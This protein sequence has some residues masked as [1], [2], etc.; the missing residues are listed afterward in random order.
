M[1]MFIRLFISVLFFVSVN[2]NAEELQL[3]NMDK[4]YAMALYEKRPDAGPGVWFCFY[5]TKNDKNLK[6]LEIDEQFLYLKINNK[7]QS[8]KLVGKIDA[9]DK[10][11]SQGQLNVILSNIHDVNSDG[12]NESFDREASVTIKNKENKTTIHMFADGCGI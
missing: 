1:G 11:F 6:L 9:K 7:Y 12:Y 10:K 2:I 5:H 4:E 3:E 8:L